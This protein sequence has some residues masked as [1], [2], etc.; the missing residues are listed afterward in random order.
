[1]K[2]HSNTD[3]G[4]CFTI[5][6]YGRCRFKCLHASCSSKTINDFISKYPCP[7]EFLLKES[8]TSRKEVPT[9]ED[10]INGKRYNFGD[11]EVSKSGIYK[12]SDKKTEIISSTPFFISKS[13]FNIDTN[14][15]Q[16]E[17]QYLIQG[18]KNT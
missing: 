16:Y 6:K 5:T 10:L 4:A 13:F 1:M 9:L 14:H 11:Y 3:S 15:F 7:E 12:I 18:K 17:F 8:S 2:E